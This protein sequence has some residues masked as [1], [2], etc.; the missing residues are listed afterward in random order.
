MLLVGSKIAYVGKVIPFIVPVTEV[1]LRTE[2]LLLAE[3]ATY[4]LPFAVV[5]PYGLAPTDMVAVTV[6]VAVFITETVLLP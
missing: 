6:F 4:T 3:F 2:I 1:P 5:I